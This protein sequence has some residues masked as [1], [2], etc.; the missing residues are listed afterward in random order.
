MATTNCGRKPPFVVPPTGG[1]D[2]RI[3][4]EIL[5]L[6]ATKDFPR[7]AARRRYARRCRGARGV[8]RCHRA[9]RCQIHRHALGASRC[10][11]GWYKPRRRIDAGAAKLRDVLLN[12]TGW[13]AR[14]NFRRRKRQ[15][16][17]VGR[18]ASG[19]RTAYDVRGA[20][21]RSYGRYGP[22]CTSADR[23][24]AHCRWPQ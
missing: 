10:V 13:R 19:G 6:T 2:Q 5:S 7:S 21:E 12:C 16:C 9:G 23:C 8:S 3:G 24:G 11:R 22:G 17:A 20:A 1:N 18:W 4:A 15:S 14:R